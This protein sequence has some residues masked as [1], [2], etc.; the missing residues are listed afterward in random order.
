MLTVR[1]G[2]GGDEPVDL[3]TTFYLPRAASAD[4]KVPA[5]LLAHG[6]GGTKDSVRADA[7]DL[8][9]R[10]YAVLT[11]TARGFGRSGGQIHLDSPDYEVR[12]AQRL[13][14]WLAARP[15]MRTD[16]AGDPRVGVVGG[17]YGGAL[18]LL[19][20]APGPA[21]RRDRPHDHLER[22]GPRLPAGEHRRA[23]RPGRVQEGLGRPVLRGRR[24]RRLRAGRAL[25]QLR[26][27]RAG[28]RSRV[29]RCAQPWPGGGPG[30]GSSRARGP[31]PTR[32]AAGS[33]PTSARRTCAS[34]PP[35][36]PTRP[37]VDLL[38]RSSPAD[39]LGRIKA[40][41]PADPGR[42]RT[43]CSR[44][45][46]RTP[47]RAASPPPAP[48][49]GWPGSPAATTAAPARQ[50]D[51]DRV[52]FLTVSGWTTT[53]RA[54]GRPPGDELHLLPGRRLRRP[55]R[56]LVTTGLLA[57]PTTPGVTGGRP[58]GGAC[59]RPGPADRQPAQRQPG[60]DLGDARRRSAAGSAC[61]TG[62]PATYPA[63]TPTSTPRR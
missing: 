15:D 56:G 30:S 27:R 24:Q 43:P 11:W 8:A 26:R 7:E 62:W 17:S 20:A 18:A 22:P 4:R 10:G 45:A 53:S 50:S 47:T 39:V 60:R 1:S 51:S 28:G 63:S 48:R 34:P 58:P 12:D 9:D 13:L 31:P 19:L 61:S 44:W 57:P 41:D 35:G 23:G 33:P 21:G 52:K 46:R 42:R 55:D 54:P 14:D 32:P 40:P 2:P 6:F 5:V 37:T 49:S 3:D 38:R 59:R 36:G 29:G 25:R 16:A